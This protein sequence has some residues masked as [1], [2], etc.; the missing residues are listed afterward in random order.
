M[1]L[2][3]LHHYMDSMRQK[4]I[5]NGILSEFRTLG[6]FFFPTILKD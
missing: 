1:T 5:N 6:A 2:L 3:N 4:A